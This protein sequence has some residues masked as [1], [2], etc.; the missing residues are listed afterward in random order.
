M[1]VTRTL[2]PLHFEDLEPHRFE[3]LVRELVY[4]FND[5][6]SIEATGRSGADDG[7]DIRAYERASVTE[8]EPEDGEPEEDDLAPHP[9]EGNLWMFQCKRQAQ[10]G[11]TK[12]AQIIDDGV[13]A[14]SPPYGYVLAA[15]A[16]FS[17]K[18][19]DVFR[20]ELRKRGVMEFFLWG[21]A[22]LED[23]LHW[24]RDDRVLFTFFGISLVTRRRS[25]ATDIR[26]IVARKN[27]LM[28]ILG[29]QPRHEPILA[30]DTK[31][32]HYPHS[33][34]YNDFDKRPRWRA[35][36]VQELTPQGLVVS[37]QEHF[38]Y[39]D[40]PQ[41]EWDMTEALNLAHRP[42]EEDHQQ[43]RSNHELRDRI[44]A[45]WHFFP[46]AKRANFV[47]NGLIKFDDIAVIDDKGD[48]EFKFPHLY[49]DFSDK[50]GPFFGFWEYL[51][52]HEHQR[53]RLDGLKRVKLFP[54]TFDA[55]RM[56]TLHRGATLKIPDRARYLLRADNPTL[57]TLYDVDG[58]LDFLGEADVIAIEGTK[59]KVGSV[60]EPT[61]IQVTHKRTI[62]GKVFLDSLVDDPTI[63]H[64]VEE[65]V[66]R[67][68]TEA[69]QLRIVEFKLTYAW[70]LERARSASP[71][72]GV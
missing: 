31:D 15:P 45:F 58:R 69:D 16:N 72:A 40:E 27:K 8:A 34:S 41:G 18:S 23:M 24:P 12:V 48:S 63:K 28:R 17:K 39:W 26:A 51:T 3:D 65:Q 49:V 25:R 70:A 32:T 64:R 62:S 7:F 11:P 33:S 21:R 13:K 4:D 68:V 5:W 54:S 53:Q 22:A 55:P 44:E 46:H 9:M 47:R 29:E 71:A 1:A 38:A 19:F 61:L 30:R 20:E 60:D 56:G 14:D 37:V 67:E 42:D 52:R 10:I 2:G 57:N 6:Q 59:G 50:N 35:Y 43:R 36:N 66:G